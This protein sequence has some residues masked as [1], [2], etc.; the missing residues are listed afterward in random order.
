MTT[1]VEG[2]IQEIGKQIT[3]VIPEEWEQARVVV[4]LTAEDVLSMDA[5]YRKVGE[6]EEIKFPIGAEL[7]QSLLELR[8]KLKRD[9]ADSWQKAVLTLERTGSFD[10]DLSY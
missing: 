7:A 5:W 2:N 3:Q 4:E 9:D 10:L 1:S 6:A 8:I